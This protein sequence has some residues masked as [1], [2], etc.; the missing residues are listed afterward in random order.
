MALWVIP[1]SLGF[2]GGYGF[3]RLTEDKL[4]QVQTILLRVV[5]T[6]IVRRRLM[7]QRQASI[8]LSYLEEMSF[9]TRGRQRGLRQHLD[10]RRGISANLYQLS[11]RTL[12]NTIST[13]TT[14]GAVDIDVPTQL[15][16]AFA[17]MIMVPGES[18]VCLRRY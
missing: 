10:L 6:S 8:K 4:P 16:K 12:L 15:K 3:R 17:K 11:M 7:G 1:Q 5:L 9:A 14:S 2:D 18:C 13:L